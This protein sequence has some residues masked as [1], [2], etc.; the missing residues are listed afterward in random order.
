[1][2]GRLLREGEASA[3]AVREETIALCSRF[4]LYPEL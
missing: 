4:P 3:P 1:M 2:I